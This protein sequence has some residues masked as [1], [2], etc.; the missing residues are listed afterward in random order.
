MIYLNLGRR[1]QGKTTLAYY[2]V[3]KQPTRVIFDPRGL[4]PTAH[5]LTTSDEVSSAFDRLYDTHPDAER[6]QDVE[7]VITPEVDVQG[8]FEVT[9]REVKGWLQAGHPIAFLV[10]EV[11]MVQTYIRGEFHEFNWIL[12][13]CPRQQAIIVL[14]AHRPVDVSVDVRAISDVW[15]LFA[16]TQ[17]HDLNVIKQRCSPD[18]AAL[19]P[20]LATYHFVQW[21]EGKG[22]GTVNK[23][24]AGWYLKLKD[25]QPVSRSEP[26]PIAGESLRRGSSGSFFDDD[27]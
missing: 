15:L 26:V 7:L 24:P 19:L 12:R 22:T 4:F 16:M 13:L 11:S 8:L 9:S 6:R 25:V 23:N 1:E 18:V 5:R 17:E 2:L 10:D 21:D 14:T 20:R 3:S 27:K